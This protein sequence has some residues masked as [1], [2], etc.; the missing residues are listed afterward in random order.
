LGT[1]RNDGLC[2]FGMI[3]ILIF[4]RNCNYYIIII[5]LLLS[6]QHKPR[7]ASL[8]CPYRQTQPILFESSAETSH[9][10]LRRISARE[11]YGTYVLSPLADGALDFT[12]R[13]ETVEDGDTTRKM[14]ALRRKRAHPPCAHV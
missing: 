4:S 6:L 9:S 5:I 2:L 12:Y 8:S 7:C 14:C 11:L 10:L 3:E 13:A 1:R